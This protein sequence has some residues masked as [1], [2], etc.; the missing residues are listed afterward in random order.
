M[1]VLNSRFSPP[2][3]PGERPLC[4]GE[5]VWLPGGA[6]EGFS[7][8]RNR[9]P[10]IRRLSLTSV[11]GRAQKLAQ[12]RGKASASLS[13]LEALLLSSHFIPVSQ[14]RQQRLQVQAVPWA[15]ERLL[16]PAVPP[17][18]PGWCQEPRRLET[19][20]A[21]QPVRPLPW[22]CKGGRLLVSEPGPQRPLGPR[23]P[24]ARHGSGHHTGRLW[25]R[26]HGL[27]PGPGW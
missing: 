12:C 1:A 17:A 15:R 27:R 25:G 2:R 18:R 24:P 23:A 21:R 10:A 20:E 6:G 26:P 5:G 13:T 3:P 16:G 8:G 19:G 14:V 7:P 11:A 22:R 9:A 4:V